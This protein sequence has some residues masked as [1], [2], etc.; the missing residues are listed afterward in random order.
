M[1]Q[2]FL[3]KVV[4]LFLFAS[5]WAIGASG[6]ETKVMGMINSRTGE[7]LMIQGSS[8]TTAVI[9]TAD[10]K[11][12]DV[13]ALGREET[14][15]NAVLI[16]GLKVRV[17][18]TT[19][20]QGSLK[21][22]KITVDGDDLETSEM[23]QAGVH[24]LQQQLDANAKA[25]EAN[26]QAI[27]ALRQEL[28]A[29]KAQMPQQTAVAAV[30]PN[31]RS[32]EETS[33]RFA[34]LTEFDVQDQAVVKFDVGSSTISAKEQ[35]ALKKLAEAAAGMKG[36][37]IEVMGYTDSTGNPVMNTRL[38]EA[39]A[40]AVITYLVQQGQIPI[41]RIVAPGAM[42]ENQPV[43]SNE[44]AAGRAENRRVEA[45]LLVNRGLQEAEGLR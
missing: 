20:G 42:G 37:V 3:P 26:Q 12:K 45:K 19:D 5:L 15:D 38:S 8:G 9:L 40:K 39:R 36:Y 35:E 22:T 21:A 30:Q 33:E 14:M 13:R 18:G 29:A 4:P 43:G 34:A 23:I 2:T 25:I 7:T 16:P 11:I 32:S 31:I 6:Q 24:P 44:N 41:R 27:A 28:A 17:D 10:T 1:Q